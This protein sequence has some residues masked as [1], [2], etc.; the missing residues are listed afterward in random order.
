MCQNNPMII[1]VNNTPYTNPKNHPNPSFITSLLYRIMC[2]FRNIPHNLS[3]LTIYKT[4]QTMPVRI[5]ERE[6]PLPFLFA[7]VYLDVRLYHAN[8]FTFVLVSHLTT[9]PF[10]FKR[11]HL[12]RTA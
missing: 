2:L 10:F 11:C 1:N 4:N 3:R 9:E 6:T 8:E 7:L 12:R 5:R